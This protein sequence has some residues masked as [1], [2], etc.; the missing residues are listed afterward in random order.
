MKITVNQLRRIIKEEVGKILDREV[1]DHERQDEARSILRLGVKKWLTD[2]GAG[3]PQIVSALRDIIELESL[4][5]EDI[6][7][8][9]GILETE[10]GYD[11]DSIMDLDISI[12]DALESGDI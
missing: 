8:E 10:L 2:P 11:D 5:N 3:W 4:S 1:A 12:Q 7:D 6:M 9:I